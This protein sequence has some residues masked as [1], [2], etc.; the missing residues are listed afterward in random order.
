M[1]VVYWH[2]DDNDDATGWVD[3]YVSGWSM[4]TG[5]LQAPVGY[6]K[7]SYGI[8]EYWGKHHS[9]FAASRSLGWGEGFVPGDVIGCAICFQEGEG[10]IYDDDE[11]NHPEGGEEDSTKQQQQNQKNHIRF[12]KNGICMGHFVISKGKREGGEAFWALNAASTI[13]QSRATWVGVSN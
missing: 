8:R 5:D 7:W 4:R 2:D 1:S 13:Q 6:D 11:N 3:T 12:F 10:L 9:L